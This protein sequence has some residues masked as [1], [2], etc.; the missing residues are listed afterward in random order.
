MIES[1]VFTSR[2]ISSEND[3]YRDKGKKI[4]FCSQLA[5]HV[6]CIILIEENPHCRSSQI[7]Q[8]CPMYI[9]VEQSVI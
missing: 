2:N 7:L 9:A 3:I 4:K 6:T 1:T 8:S 5:T